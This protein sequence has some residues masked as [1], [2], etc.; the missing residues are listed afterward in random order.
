[1]IT[2][3][4]AF[5]VVLDTCVLAPMPLCDTLLRLAEDP[6]FYMPAREAA[7]AGGGPRD[8]L[9]ESGS[10]V[11]KVGAIAAHAAVDR[12][13]PVRNCG[14]DAHRPL[15]RHLNHP[16]SLAH[17]DCGNA[18]PQRCR[19]RVLDSPSRRSQ[20]SVWRPMTPLPPACARGWQE[21][22]KFPWLDQGHP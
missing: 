13:G 12:V 15:I 2:Q 7:R 8:S 4:N 11:G 5:V 18:E 16:E 9:R 21:I 10:Q 22:F 3:T 14:N 1:M 19:L 20:A 6:A 17:R